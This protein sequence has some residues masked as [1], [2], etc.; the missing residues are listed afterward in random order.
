M[1][2]LVLISA[3]FTF[4]AVV[5][6]TLFLWLKSKRN[7]DMSTPAISWKVLGELDLKTGI[8]PD[9]IEKHKNKFVRVAGFIVPLDDSASQVSEFLLVPYA[10][11]CIHLPPPPD[12][13]MVLVQMKEP[14]DHIFQGRAVWVQG[15]LSAVKASHSYGSASYSML[16]TG[17]D[18]VLEKDLDGLQ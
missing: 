5:S 8:V 14:H 13:Q 7:V 12:N 6:V 17:L 10:Q 4:L 18:F 9:E 3:L 2:K 15:Q 11:A 16:G 1:R